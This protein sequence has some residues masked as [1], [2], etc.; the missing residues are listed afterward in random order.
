MKK[1][2]YLIMFS[3]FLTIPIIVKAD[4]SYLWCEATNLA[5]LQKL[6]ANITSSYD[7]VE[8]FTAGSKFGNVTFTIKLN[9]LSE[10]LYLVNAI[11]NER[12]NYISSEIVIPN[13]EHGTTIPFEI[14]GNDYNCEEELILTIY[15]NIPPYNQYYTDDLCKN[16]QNNKLCNRWYKINLSYDEFKT[17]LSKYIK[18]PEKTQDEEEEEKTFQDIFIEVVAFLDKYK[19]FIFGPIVTI[20]FIAILYLKYLKKKEEF[21]LK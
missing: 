17:E 2:I 3:I 15:V 9:N 18:N 5:K 10:K 16:L 8:T 19:F 13:I 7:Y 21:D 11:T 4:T 20:S 12:Y 14:Y 6:A 1:A